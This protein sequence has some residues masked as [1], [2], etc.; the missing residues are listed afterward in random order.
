MKLSDIYMQVLTERR[1][2]QATAEATLEAAHAALKR[3][4]LKAGATMLTADTATING[5]TAVLGRNIGGG[6]YLYIR[7]SGVTVTSDHVHKAPEL[8]S[9]AVRGA[10]SSIH[11]NWA[12]IEPAFMATV[13]GGANAGKAA[14]GVGGAL[15]EA[16]SRAG[17]VRAKKAS[18]DA[19]LLRNAVYAY[20]DGWLR[21][22]GTPGASTV[23]FPAVRSLVGDDVD[24]WFEIAK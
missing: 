18:K 17:R 3:E 9:E 1:E 7:S 8:Y 19:R 23:A 2:A 11:S 5:V 6:G 12:A 16:F 15:A 4:M 20:H 22:S 24:E 13:N 10:V 21:P 14:Q